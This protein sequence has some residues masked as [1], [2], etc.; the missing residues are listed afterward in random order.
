M[1]YVNLLE[2]KQ[3]GAICFQDVQAV[4]DFVGILS[5]CCGSMMVHGRLWD[6]KSLVG[7]E[8]QFFQF[9]LWLCKNSY[10]KSQFLM[11]KSTI[12]GN[13]Q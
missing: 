2:V 12:N 9:T 4:M 1:V 5:D 8:W 10:G 3:G 7:Q 11:G 13:F 6:K